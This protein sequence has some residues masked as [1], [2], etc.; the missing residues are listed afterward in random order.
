MF[1]CDCH[2]CGRRELRGPRS[3]FPLDG[4]FAATCRR[5]GS[6]V[7][8]AGTRVARPAAAPAPQAPAE[9]AA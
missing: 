3:L 5:C 2:R 4:G 1:L 7:A 9:T 8:V 6:T